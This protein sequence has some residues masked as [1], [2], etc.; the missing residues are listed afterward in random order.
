MT[1]NTSIIEFDNINNDQLQQL[2]GTIMKM[3]GLVEK[4]RLEELMVKYN[5]KRDKYRSI[6]KNI[7]NDHKNVVNGL[8]ME[9]DR[10]IGVRNSLI[11]KTGGYGKRIKLLETNEI[12][13]QNKIKLLE[14]KYKEEQA[15]HKLEIAELKSKILVKCSG[16]FEYKTIN[17]KS[18]NLCKACVLKCEDMNRPFDTCKICNERCKIF[19]VSESI[20]R[21]CY[22]TVHIIGES[23]NITMKRRQENK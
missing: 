12:Q 20:C 18:K 7:Y 19:I 13:Y 8:N 3:F 22:N 11:G 1:T 9:I 16:C 23:I 15:K 14:H 4:K 6:I 2:Q 5:T 10:L 21:P 17:N